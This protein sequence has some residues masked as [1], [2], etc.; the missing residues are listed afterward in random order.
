MKSLIFIIFFALLEINAYSQTSNF[1]L[2]R[3]NFCLAE[4]LPLINTSVN[5]DFYEWDFCFGDFET[6]P[7]IT[8]LFNITDLTLSQGFK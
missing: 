7:S 2:P 4:N 3:D 8:S 6:E 1:T 5:S